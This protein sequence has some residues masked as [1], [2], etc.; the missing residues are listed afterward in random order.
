MRANINTIAIIVTTLGLTAC[1]NSPQDTENAENAPEQEPWV[2][3]DSGVADG[4]ELAATGPDAESAN[5]ILAVGAAASAVLDSE[6]AQA[7]MEDE[8]YAAITAIADDNQA[9]PSGPPVP[10][11]AECV[12]P[13]IALGGGLTLAF[14]ACEGLEG[15]ANLQRIERGLYVASFSEEF[16]VD[17]VNI[18][19]AVAM[20]RDEAGIWTIYSADV[21]AEAATI[22]VVEPRSDSEVSLDATMELWGNGQ[23]ETTT[24]YGQASTSYELGQDEEGEYGDPLTWP[25]GAE[26]YCPTSGNL[27]AESV[28][29][30][31]EVVLDLDD[32]INTPADWFEPRG[33][34]LEEPLT[35]EISLTVAMTGVCG[36]FDI[37]VQAIPEENEVTVPVEEVVAAIEAV[38]A[39]LDTAILRNACYDLA[40]SI[41][42]G[43]T[44]EI[45]DEVQEAVEEAVR[46]VFEG[47]LCAM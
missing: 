43:I 26:C 4:L 7:M 13:S 28:Y 6:D 38:C 32:Y 15:Q 9:G 12:E 39:E 37:E 20:G 8:D 19:G 40:D 23:V 2:M 18:T 46:E 34:E 27:R 36:E 25:L 22:S 16:A 42:S 31:Q 1:G 41:D 14:S 45:G 5:A 17:D 35:V 3:I 11:T 24:A 44:V 47:S 29:E 30:V 21:E 10:S 33:Y